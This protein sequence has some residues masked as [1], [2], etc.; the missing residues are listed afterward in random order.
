MDLLT[1]ATL[2][3]TGIRKVTELFSKGKELMAEVK[4]E[5]S[6][7]TTPDELQAE[8]EK[9]S[10]DQQKVWIDKMAAAT[11]QYEA[12]TERLKA[13]ES[14]SSELS[15]KVDSETASE[16][17]YMR[18]TTRPWAVRQMVR[19]ILFP[20]YIIGLDVIQHLLKNWLFF[21]TDKVKPFESFHYVF[22]TTGNSL[23]DKLGNVIGPMPKTLAGQMYIEAIGVAVWVIMSYMGLRE[24]GKFRGKEKGDGILGKIKKINFFSKI[25]A[26]K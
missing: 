3:F 20:F 4:G 5:A 24:V 25:L 26:G 12:E 11:N 19:V 16:I 9:L 6:I 7:I 13:Q 1:G 17:S 14:I 2:L 8:F 15:S 10:P 18:Q 23:M 21:W 22:G